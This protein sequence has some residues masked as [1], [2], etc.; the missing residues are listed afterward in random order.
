[1][2]SHFTPNLQVIQ[3]PPQP[4]TPPADPIRMADAQTLLRAIAV[5][6]PRYRERGAEAYR[7]EVRAFARILDKSNLRLDHLLEGVQR[8]YSAPDSPWNPLGAVLEQARAARRDAGQGRTLHALP[9]A[10]PSTG[11]VANA[12][13][14]ILDHECRRCGAPAGEHCRHPGSHQAKRV[15]CIARRK[16]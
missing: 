8:T 13:T 7:D 11:P 2:V 15:P 1:M 4:P 3:S 12:Y 6:D 14:G 9:S 16:G 5:F 10:P